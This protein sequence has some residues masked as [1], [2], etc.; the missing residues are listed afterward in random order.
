MKSWNQSAGTLH[1]W[2][3]MACHK[4]GWMKMV[5]KKT[6]FRQA[7]SERAV[8]AAVLLVA[9]ST[10]HTLGGHT[11]IVSKAGLGTTMVGSSLL[12]SARESRRRRGSPLRR[13]PMATKQAW[14]RTK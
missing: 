2:L 11:H 10:P 12:P 8:P 1:F 3:L 9:S 7:G 13:L 5:C 6:C 4:G 14:A